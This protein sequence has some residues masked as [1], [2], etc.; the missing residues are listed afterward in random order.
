[1]SAS[2][3]STT[4]SLSR[5][6]PSADRGRRIH[7]VQLVVSFI[8]GLCRLRQDLLGANREPLTSGGDHKK[9]Y[10]DA[11]AAPHRAAWS[12]ILNGSVEPLP[13]GQP[14]AWLSRRKLSWPPVAASA[15][16]L[17][18]CCA[19]TRGKDQGLIVLATRKP[20]VSNR[21][22]VWRLARTAARTSSL[23]LRQEPPRTT[24]KLGSP[25]RS[26]ADPS[27]GAPS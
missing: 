23:S 26:H 4:R 1:M 25:P 19:W 9:D 3:G 22:L 7:R 10:D 11:F 5:R 24:R 12:F 20:R 15:S 6:L 14:G 8:A 2:L 27:V 21:T 18:S 13:P 17:S 16:K